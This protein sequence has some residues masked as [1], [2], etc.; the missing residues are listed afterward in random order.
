MTKTEA[1]KRAAVSLKYGYFRPGTGNNPIPG[2]GSL[3]YL[4]C[5]ICQQHVEYDGMAWDVKQTLASL[6]DHMV[7]EH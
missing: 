4:P 5:P 7:E 3:I 6:T 2:T 1:R